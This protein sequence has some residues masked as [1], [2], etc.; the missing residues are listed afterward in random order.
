MTYFCIK[1]LI[2]I[3]K[4][5]RSSSTCC[6]SLVMFDWTD[7]WRWALKR[8]WDSVSTCFWKQRVFVC[9]FFKHNLNSIRTD[10]WR[11]AGRERRPSWTAA[12]G[13]PPQPADPPAWAE[14]RS[15]GL[16][17]AAPRRRRSPQQ[18]R[19]PSRRLG[20]GRRVN[21]SEP[22]WT[23]Q[24]NRLKQLQ[25]ERQDPSGVDSPQFQH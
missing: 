19:R 5:S 11:R 12:P 6:S 4:V 18:T 8:W 17:H 24:T 15:G 16:P 21:H 2:F 10:M 14:S 13:A 9:L 22:Q 1:I 25:A 7:S 20:W 3:S 23:T